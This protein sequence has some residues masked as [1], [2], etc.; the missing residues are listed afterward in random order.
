[1]DIIVIPIAFSCSQQIV[2]FL[3]PKVPCGSLF[4]DIGLAVERLQSQELVCGHLEIFGQQWEHVD[5]RLPFADGLEGHA[6]VVRQL[7][8]CDLFL[9]AQIGNAQ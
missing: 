9:F 2:Q 8:L 7:L 3:V 4:G 1:M 5:P 6:D